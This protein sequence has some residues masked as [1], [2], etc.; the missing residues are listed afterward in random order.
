MKSLLLTEAESSSTSNARLMYD[1]M[2]ALLLGAGGVITN[3]SLSLFSYDNPTCD[4]AH[5]RI[6]LSPSRSFRTWCV[7]SDACKKIINS[8]NTR[9]KQASRRGDTYSISFRTALRC[10]SDAEGCSKG[11][12]LNFIG[13]AFSGQVWIYKL[14]ELSF[15]YDGICLHKRNSN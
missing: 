4:L 14:C 6:S 11:H 2:L 8:M 5:L 1:W 10:L 15:L 12:P 3:S 9:A 13:M 7:H